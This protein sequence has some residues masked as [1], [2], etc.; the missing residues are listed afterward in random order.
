V[1]RSGAEWA[2]KANMHPT[3]RGGAP[4]AK[5]KAWCGEFDLRDEKGKRKKEKLHK[6]VCE[7][8]E[9]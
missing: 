8:G 3:M 9:E 5:L 7:C 6:F 4:G 1:G 2:K